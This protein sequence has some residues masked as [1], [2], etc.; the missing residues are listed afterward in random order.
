MT[1]F[2]CPLD[3]CVCIRGACAD[4][5]PGTTHWVTCAT[6]R[7]TVNWTGAKHFASMWPIKLWQAKSG[8]SPKVESVHGY[9]L[10]PSSIVNT[11][12]YIIHRTCTQIKRAYTVWTEDS[13]LLFWQLTRSQKKNPTMMLSPI[14]TWVTC[15]HSFFFFFKYI[16][17]RT[18][19]LLLSLCV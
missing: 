10:F 14:L 8:V 4:V 11:L 6:R 12:M 7:V 17:N 16:P 13:L 3:L 9:S 18:Y 15:R 5:T 19:R 1:V 2:D